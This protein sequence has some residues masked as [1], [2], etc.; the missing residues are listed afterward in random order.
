MSGRDRSAG[1]ACCARADG[2]KLAGQDARRFPSPQSETASRGVRPAYIRSRSAYI[3]RG[4]TKR[5]VDLDDDA[6][7]AARAHLGTSTI[8]DTVNEALR[9]AAAARQGELRQALE[10]LAELELDDRAASWR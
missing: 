7:A 2:P 6:L 10:I 3:L 9:Q 5:L 8:K 4:V 1:R